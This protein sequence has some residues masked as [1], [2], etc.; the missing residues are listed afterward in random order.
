MIERI[1]KKYVKIEELEKSEIR[2]NNG[3]LDRIRVARQNLTEY[4]DR[5]TLDN[6]RNVKTV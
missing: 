5:L 4:L 1:I 3:N 6:E 2:P